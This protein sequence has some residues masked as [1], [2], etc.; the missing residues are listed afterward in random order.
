MTAV[1]IIIVIKY[2][3]K[4]L[5]NNRKFDPIPRHQIHRKRLKIYR[6]GLSMALL[7]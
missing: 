1:K 7:C 6:L 2:M 5:I 4:K 3:M